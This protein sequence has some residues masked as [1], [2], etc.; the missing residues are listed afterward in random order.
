MDGTSLVNIVDGTK[1]EMGQ[2]SKKTN[3]WDSILKIFGWD[4]NL[5]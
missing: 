2:Y 4:R 1:T 3:G 5:K